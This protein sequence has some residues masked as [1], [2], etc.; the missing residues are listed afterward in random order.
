MKKSD[1][2]TY[3]LNTPEFE[4]VRDIRLIVEDLLK[5][6][7]SPQQQDYNLHDV[8]NLVDELRFHLQYRSGKVIV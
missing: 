5:I 6:K 4:K 3:I 1:L 7:W 2:I 8:K